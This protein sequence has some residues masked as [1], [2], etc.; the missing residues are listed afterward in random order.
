MLSLYTS[1]SDLDISLSAGHLLDV[2]VRSLNLNKTT[3]FRYKLVS[4]S[5]AGCQLRSLIFN[6]TTRYTCMIWYTNQCMLSPDE[7]HCR[8]SCSLLP[9]QTRLLELSS[10]FLF[11]A[12]TDLPDTNCTYD[13]LYRF[14]AHTI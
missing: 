2:F 4:R 7:N 11:T 9:L 10:L 1:I 6:K 14:L 8:K 5:S 13:L 3:R 12:T